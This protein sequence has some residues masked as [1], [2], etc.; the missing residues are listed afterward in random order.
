MPCSSMC[1]AEHR[2]DAP[3]GRR[4]VAV[5]EGDFK[6]TSE[7]A[8][9][10]LARRGAARVARRRLVY[11]TCSIDTEENEA[12]VKE[13][14]NSRAADLQAGVERAEPAMGH[15]TRRRGGVSAGSDKVGP[16]VLCTVVRSICRVGHQRSG[17]IRRQM[18]SRRATARARI[19]R[20]FLIRG[21]RR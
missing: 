4:E 14:F 2:R 12:V 17:G 13:F 18:R 20:A 16:D 15:R 9:R 7:T 10:A 5:A 21:L 8:T 11:S 6:K 3:T 1:H 19:L